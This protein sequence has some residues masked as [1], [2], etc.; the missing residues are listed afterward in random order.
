MLIDSF[1]DDHDDPT[2]MLLGLVADQ[3]NLKWVKNNWASMLID[4]FED[5]HNDTTRV[6]C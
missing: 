3:L 1:E 2:R 4:S 6:W 5:D